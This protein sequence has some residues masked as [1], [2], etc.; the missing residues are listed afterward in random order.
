MRDICQ[1]TGK[2]QACLLG[3]EINGKRLGKPGD[4]LSSQREL[5]TKNVGTCGLQDHQ[6]RG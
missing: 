3:E 4:S 6:G 5:R 1:L 2:I